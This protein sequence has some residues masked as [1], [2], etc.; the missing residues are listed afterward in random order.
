[1]DKLAQ[2]KKVSEPFH[3]FYRNLKTKDDLR[4][5]YPDASEDEEEK[6]LVSL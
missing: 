6:N 1:M 5:I 3:E 2:T 4:D